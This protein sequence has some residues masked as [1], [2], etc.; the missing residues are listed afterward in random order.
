MW[1]SRHF[2]Y[3]CTCSYYIISPLLKPPSRPFEQQY[4]AIPERICS[5]MKYKDCHMVL[6]QLFNE[7]RSR[8]E[9]RWNRRLPP[10]H[11]KGR[12]NNRYLDW[13]PGWKLKGVLIIQQNRSN[14]GDIS[15]NT[16][17]TCECFY[18]MIM[19]KLIFSRL[20]ITYR[21]T[22]KHH[23]PLLSGSCSQIVYP[24]TPRLSNYISSRSV[25]SQLMRLWYL[26][27]RRPAKAQASLR[28]RIVSPGSSLFAHMKYAS[29][30]RVRPKIRH[31]APLDGCACAFEGWVFGG[32]LVS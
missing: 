21:D 2:L 24:I 5:M 11:Y 30:R 20:Q 28:I 13:L 22:L 10:T 3:T 31:L 9:S 14:T 23:S 16:T 1:I 29:R 17:D 18:H 15:D 6:H 32:R 8:V 26:S 25:M 4:S 7:R 12:Y 19:L 27:H